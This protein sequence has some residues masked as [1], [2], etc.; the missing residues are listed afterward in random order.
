MT[1]TERFETALVDAYRE[2][3]TSNPEYACAASTTTPEALAH[4]MTLGLKTGSASKNGEGVNRAC[5]QCGIKQTY[6]AIRAF[7]EGFTIL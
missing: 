4:K 1:N 2:L 3:F 6:T 5:R 7:L